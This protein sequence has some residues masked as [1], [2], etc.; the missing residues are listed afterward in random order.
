MIPSY[1]ATPARLL[2]LRSAAGALE[3]TPFFANSEAPGR[4]GGMDCVRLL[5][6]LY[7][8]TGAIG[9]IEIP[10]QRMDHG[11]HSAHSLL[12]EAF[13]TWPELTTRFACVWRQT[14]PEDCAPLA[15]CLPG[16]AL[17][18]LAG[19]APHHGGVLLEGAEMVHVLAGP[20]V[21][22]LSLRAVVRG[23]NALG[24]LAAVFRPLP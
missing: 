1:Y 23:Q 5:H 4:D 17:C 22:M 19:K 10:R 14:N 15:Q 7:R 9:R 13:D 2:A 8:T 6:W 20:G 16:D 12:I 18:F 24:R 11:Q 3:R 21:H